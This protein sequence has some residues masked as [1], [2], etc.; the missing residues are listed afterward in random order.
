MKTCKTTEYTRG[1]IR[2]GIM[3]KIE[4]N[5]ENDVEDVLIKQSS[6][7]SKIGEELFW[8]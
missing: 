1:K 2:N 3:T 7:T 6:Y 8:D 5:N 4:K